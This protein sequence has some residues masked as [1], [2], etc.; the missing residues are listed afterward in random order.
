LAFCAETSAWTTL[1]T[2]PPARKCASNSLGSSES[3]A[4]VLSIIDETITE[5]GTLRQRIKINCNRLILTPETS[6]ENHNPTGM[7]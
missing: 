2:L 7:K 3:P 6:A 5:G 1:G 4:F